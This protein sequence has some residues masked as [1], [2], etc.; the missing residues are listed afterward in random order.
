[1][2]RALI[3][4]VLTALAACGGGGGGGEDRD[5]VPTPTVTASVAAPTPTETPT[6]APG[7]DLVAWAAGSNR[8]LRS[9]DGGFTWDANAVVGVGDAVDFVD[10]DVGWVS[11]TTGTGGRL[12]HTID[13]GRTWT[14]EALDLGDPPPFFFD[15]DA[16]D[17]DHAV[18][19]GS[20]NR[21]HEPF[22]HRGPPAI[23]FTA[24]A[25]AAW[26]RS[27]LV[28]LDL[29]RLGKFITS[30][31]CLTTAGHGLAFVTDLSTFSSS[32]VLVTHDAG[33]T[34]QQP[35]ESPPTAPHTKV[36]CAGEHD[37]WIAGRGLFHSPDAGATWENRS[38]TIPRPL[39]VVAIRFETPSDG[40]V[41]G[42][43]DHR[44]VVLHTLDGGRQWTSSE[45]RYPTGFIDVTAGLDFQGEDGVVV[46][47]DLH[48][49]EIPRSSFGVAFATRDGGSSWS[50]TEFPAPINALWDV[51]L[52][53]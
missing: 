9:G 37:L 5:A 18:V 41:I 27:E 30:S 48:P 33:A 31:I 13:G 10:R 22:F 39:P 44:V 3:L 24:D 7:P 32:F 1:M 50:V 34:W 21:L 53:P 36:A 46:L 38:F 16:S 52:V 8:L 45:L 47:Q 28:G 40:R 17:R 35:A 12:L 2:R 42:F 25:G 23:F 51:A 11:G 29:L 19:A 49:F 14:E 26:R 6:S 43:A 4:S 20:E 15:V